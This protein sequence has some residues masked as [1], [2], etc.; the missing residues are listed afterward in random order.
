M[1][2]LPAVV[3]FVAMLFSRSA[4][5]PSCKRI[6][7]EQNMLE[8]KPGTSSALPPGMTALNRIAA[9]PSCGLYNRKRIFS[10]DISAKLGGSVGA[11][12]PG[13]SGAGSGELRWFSWY[14]WGSKNL[15]GQPLLTPAHTN[16]LMDSSLPYLLS[17]PAAGLAG[18]LMLPRTREPCT[19]T[20]PKAATA[21]FCAG[22]HR[23]GSR[24]NTP[25]DTA[26]SSSWEA[27]VDGIA[28]QIGGTAAAG[29]IMGVQIGDELVDGGLTVQNLSA[30]ASRLRLRLPSGVFIYTNEGFFYD[31]PCSAAQPCPSSGAGAAICLENGLCRPHIWPFFPP[32]LDYISLDGYSRGTAEVGFVRAQYD[33]YFLPLMAPSQKLWAVPGFYG[34]NTTNATD[35][36]AID[37]QLVS[38]LEAYVHWAATDSRVVGLNAFHWPNLPLLKPSSMVMGAVAYPRLL[39]KVAQLVATLPNLSS[40]PSKTDDSTEERSLADHTEAPSKSLC[41][42]L[43]LKCHIHSGTKPLDCGGPLVPHLKCLRFE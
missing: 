8:I 5:V 26:L 42:T 16:L 25:G 37:A 2:L 29:R 7:P 24:R 13:A 15:S 27:V 21:V 12:E 6:A 28:R 3:S 32:A 41:D 9:C 33:R 11:R 39:A 23:A 19:S 35:K 43:I 31:N 22:P 30:V 1:L 36:A 10:D 38:K 14:S 40:I 18:M 4:T 20:S 34:K 17:Q